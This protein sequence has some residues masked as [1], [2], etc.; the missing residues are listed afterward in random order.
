MNIERKLPFFKVIF[1]KERKQRDAAMGIRTPV[2]GVKGRHDWP[3]YTI[4][5]GD[6]YIF[7]YRIKRV[8][9]RDPLVQTADSGDRGSFPFGGSPE[10]RHQLAGNRPGAS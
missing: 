2:A 9:E 5:A 3:D 10:C 1:E 4:A 6:P 8:L 7:V